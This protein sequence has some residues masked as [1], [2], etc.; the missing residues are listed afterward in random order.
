[1]R[2]RISLFVKLAA[3]LAVLI[4]LAFAYPA[5]RVYQAANDQMQQAVQTRLQRAADVLAKAAG[6]GALAQIGRTPEA[7]SSPAYGALLPLLQAAQAAGGL[8]SANIYYRDSARQLYTWIDANGDRP[9]HP[10][11]SATLAHQATL[12]DGQPRFTRYSDQS[13]D[14][15]A[16][17]TPVFGPGAGGAPVIIGLVETSVLEPVQ[18]LVNLETL[19]SV[20]PVLAGGLIVAVVLSLVVARLVLILPLLR[21]KNGAA[22]LARGDLGHTIRLHA[23]DEL[24]DLAAAFNQMSARIQS[25]VHERVELERRQ[26][27]GEVT[28]LQES[29]KL[30]AGRVAERTAELERR[31]WQLQTAAE[32]SHVAT[33]TLDLEALCQ[34]GVDLICERFKLYY[35]GLFLLDDAREYAWLRA[36][37]GEAG[38]TML[39]REH[40][41]PANETSM[42]G[43]CVTHGEA[44]IALDVG[45]EPVR[46]NNPV[47]P[48]TR[49]EIALPLI[50]R[51]EVIGALTIQS[52]A[53]GAFSQ[54]DVEVLQTLAN[55]LANAL[56]NARLYEAAQRARQVSE[57]LREANL[58]LTQ[59]LDLDVI[60]EKLL[61][62]LDDLVDF[63]S[64]MIIVLDDEGHWS[65]RATRGYP[66]VPTVDVRTVPANTQF[67]T[68]LASQASLIVPDTAQ[69]P[70]WQPMAGTEHVRSWL[71]VPMVAGGRVIG[72]CSLDS[73]RAEFFGLEQ[74]GLAESL[75]S[76]AAFA[77]ANARLYASAQREIGERKRAEAAE[78]EART[79]AEAAT[80]AKSVFLAT[81]SHEIRT[82]MNAIIGMTS[83]LLDTPLTA[84]QREF[85]ETVRQ[86]GDALLAIINDIL[87]FSKIESGKMELESHGFDLRECLEGA[88]DL[89]TP[90]AAAKGLELALMVEPSVP[91]AVIGD[92]TRVRQI[93]I[94][95][96]GNAVK[97]TERGEVVVAVDTGAAAGPAPRGQT[98]LHISVRDTG[99]GVPR[100]RLD[101]LFQSFSQ[102][103]A[104]TTRKYGGTG[105]GLAISRRLAEMMGGK[106]WV[107]S[108]GVPGE[109][110]VFHF[111]LCL[112]VTAPPTK[113][114][115]LQ[116]SQPPLTGK[117]LL[118]V[119]DNATN[120]RILVVQT[121]AWSMEPVAV[122]SGR[123]AL[124]E[125]QSGRPFDVALLDL[126]MPGMD[127]LQLAAEIRHLPE[128]GSLP[129]VLLSSVGD[130]EL[131]R[132][133]F[134]AVLTKPVKASQLHDVMTNLFAEQSPPP[135]RSERAAT[136]FNADTG[137]SQPLRLLL[138]ED[139]VTNQKL[140]LRLLERL[141][142]RADVAA[143]G[144]EVLQALRRQAYDAVLMDVQMP[145]MDGLEATR[146]IH[147]IWRGRLRPWI[148]AMTANAM[149]EDREACLAAGMDDYLSK[150]IRVDELI[151]VL[152]RGWSEIDAAKPR[153][154]A[155]VSP[156]PAMPAQFD[157]AAVIDLGALDELRETMDGDS[158]FM[159]ELLGTFRSESAGLL[160]DMHRAA[161]AGDAN[162]LQLAAHSLKSNGASF[163]ALRLATLCQELERS[164]KA[165]STAGA[166]EKI[167]QAEAACA[168][169][170]AALDDL[171]GPARAG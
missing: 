113:R 92:A 78:R 14:T 58:S 165:G 108:T 102:V 2:P 48:N 154:A 33:G 171:L 129:L 6:N 164:G 124:A 38:R 161:A 84:E 59:D 117:R 101:R 22:A 121:Q 107:E 96:I 80:R 170:L 26:H 18:P 114:P 39:Q 61:D 28:R 145:E 5:Y 25:L 23:Q 8:H 76:Q 132:S 140:A 136:P 97:F 37:S 79:V 31:A 10:F 166:P 19:W 21:L 72:L 67:G 34:Q 151:R 9:G 159:A 148:I 116:S 42:I 163:G 120:R 45:E 135:G 169:V 36:G 35:V 24:G 41:L 90:Q 118:I 16:Y 17:L 104:S 74:T 112:A 88:L 115:Y 62:Y 43:W 105:L 13:G 56:G 32:V 11:I 143:D 127:G 109:G 152:N 30:L 141:G 100:D 12:D 137:R 81:M 110:S 157:P 75:A 144:W 168:Q 86:S 155:E 95:L 123:E 150:P 27:A 55:N 93:L 77:I 131:G 64:A 126:Q 98:W 40:R 29:E 63:D 138:A 158:A 130:L 162:G 142:Y 47:L 87:D 53:P 4:L 46:F 91:P 111:T 70:S 133:E 15:Y 83:L 49:S 119:D 71:G 99:L 146:Q 60:C 134:A 147:Q 167:A 3:P 65:A 149:K 106:M 122:A 139:N 125:L 51:G 103:D 89:L 82:P 52:D 85:T 44:R 20:A 54:S 156:A 50:T 160:A 73:R 153:A 128:L 69:C 68:I 57:T 94:N 1:M 66:K 7:V